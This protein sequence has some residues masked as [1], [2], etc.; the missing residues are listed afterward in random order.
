MTEGPKERLPGSGRVLTARPRELRGVR[1][2]D[3]ERR[4]QP[5]PSR[6]EPAPSTLSFLA[7]LDLLPPEYYFG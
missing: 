7:N 4:P 5:P 1:L 6:P 3:P 2:I